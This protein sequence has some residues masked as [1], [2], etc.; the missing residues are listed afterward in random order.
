MLVR[1][2]SALGAG[3]DGQVSSSISL[4]LTTEVDAVITKR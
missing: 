2:I 1:V 4:R 3:A